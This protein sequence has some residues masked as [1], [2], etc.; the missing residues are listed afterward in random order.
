[1]NRAAIAGFVVAIAFMG[2]RLAARGTTERLSAEELAARVTAAL[3]ALPAASACS[4]QPIEAE[5]MVVAP[6]TG[7][8]CLTCLAVGNVLRESAR[9]TGGAGDAARVWVVA[10]TR[11]SAVVCG[12]MREE[13]IRLPVILVSR[14]VIPSYEEAERDLTVVALGPNRTVTAVARS[15]DP[16]S[17]LHIVPRASHLKD[18]PFHP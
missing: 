18:S 12:Y 5:P 11:D 15:A 17:L 13:K 14:S 3:P 6:V 1:M 10:P 7:R 16:D 9:R 4:G 2:G 8:Q